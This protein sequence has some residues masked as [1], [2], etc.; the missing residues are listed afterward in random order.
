MRLLWIFTVISYAAQKNNVYFCQGIWTNWKQML[1][2]C[3]VFSITCL[4]RFFR[5]FCRSKVESG[6]KHVV[7]TR[8][9]TP[10]GTKPGL[11]WHSHILV[12][13][14]FVVSCRMLTDYLLA[15]NTLKYFWVKLS[16]SAEH[17][18][19]RTAKRSQILGNTGCLVNLFVLTSH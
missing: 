11:K 16:F 19:S 12:V 3:P 9:V 5:V 18:A 1:R 15:T 2:I 8:K 13:T 4:Y 6:G 7:I 10:A 17:Q 14:A